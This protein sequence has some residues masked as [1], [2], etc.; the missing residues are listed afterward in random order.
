MISNKLVFQKDLI[1]QKNL[2]FEN[3]AN[4]M[5][6]NV[7]FGGFETKFYSNY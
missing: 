5:L 6:R 3:I 4:L 7:V 1:Y 2:E